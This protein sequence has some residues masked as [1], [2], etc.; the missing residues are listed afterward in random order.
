MEISK[1]TISN[2]FDKVWKWIKK[3]SQK[4]WNFLTSSMFGKIVGVLLVVF[5]SVTIFLETIVIGLI[6]SDNEKFQEIIKYFYDINIFD[7]V[8]KLNFHLIT[9]GGYLIDVV[10][11]TILLLLGIYLWKKKNY[12]K[13]KKIVI[14]IFS[15]LIIGVITFSISFYKAMPQIMIPLEKIC[16]KSNFD[17]GCKK[18]CRLERKKN[19]RGYHK[20]LFFDNGDQERFFQYIESRF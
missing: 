2:F 11:Y 7:Y 18:N 17:K 15:V 5:S 8:S 1:K 13:N 19:H 10:F 16:Q 4:I 6:H 14:A 20:K 12:F 9:G 3:C